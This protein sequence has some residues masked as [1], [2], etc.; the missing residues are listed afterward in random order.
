MVHNESAY[1]TIEL[2][3]C[4]WKE[5]VRVDIAWDFHPIFIMMD[6]LQLQYDTL[7]NQSST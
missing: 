3:I 7:T 5:S 4:E 2:G 6:C 1:T